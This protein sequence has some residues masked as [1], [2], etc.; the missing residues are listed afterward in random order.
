MASQ[1]GGN[2]EEEWETLF[3]QE[4][5]EHIQ[6]SIAMMEMEIYGE[7]KL[8]LGHE[9]VMF[10]YWRL[11]FILSHS[12]NERD[13]FAELVRIIVGTFKEDAESNL[14]HMISLLQLAEPLQRGQRNVDD[15]ESNNV[16]GETNNAAIEEVES[17]MLP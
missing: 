11:K 4:T 17:T 10:N 16:D 9:L 8:N 3:N 5:L 2:E 7:F 15:G 1:G 6:C 13:I 12:M 14:V